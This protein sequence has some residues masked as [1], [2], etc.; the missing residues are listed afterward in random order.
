MM[1][2][3]DGYDPL[4]VQMMEEE[5][6]LVDEQ[7]NVLGKASKKECMKCGRYNCKLLK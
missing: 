4:Q 7:D 3:L 6:I 5:V 2:S 1:T